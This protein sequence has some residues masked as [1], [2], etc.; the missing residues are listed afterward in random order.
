M[1]IPG[2]SSVMDMECCRSSY[3]NLAVSS[4]ASVVISVGAGGGFRVSRVSEEV[5]DTDMGR[6]W[7][8]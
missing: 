5:I 2:P 3:D 6:W 1:K 8:R 4:S 7:H